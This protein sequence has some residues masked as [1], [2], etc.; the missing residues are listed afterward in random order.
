MIRTEENWIAGPYLKDQV[1][2]MI[3]ERKLTSQD[4]VC[5]ANGYWISIHEREEIKTH[6]GI[7]VPRE[8]LAEGEE[9]TETQSSY[10]EE[11]GTDPDLS[12]APPPEVES[13]GDNTAV[14]TLSVFKGK[15]S[16]ETPSS[17]GRVSSKSA[18]AEEEIPKHPLK[19]DASFSQG[20]VMARPRPRTV[21]SVGQ[22][23]R[24]SFWQ[25]FAW[26]LML[27]AVVLLAAAI[28]ILKK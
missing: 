28:W 10:Q 24:P 2:E 6:L 4:E 3:L 12:L 11:E 14:L 19:S 22:G 9:I 27:G 18:L 5:E 25:G 8:P 23:D 21:E 13:V 20:S 1:C 16:N 26:F 15:K 7:D 17:K